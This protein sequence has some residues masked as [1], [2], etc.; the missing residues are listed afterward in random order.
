[1]RSVFSG[2]IFAVLLGSCTFPSGTEWS[3]AT[4]VAIVNY[5]LQEYVQVPVAGAAPV[6]RITTRVD[7]E[8]TVDWKDEASNPLDEDYLFIENTVYMAQI[9]LTAK[10]GFVFTAR[11]FK[12]YPSDAVDTQPEDNYDTKKRVLSTITYKKTVDTKNISAWDLDLTGRIPAPVGGAIPVTSFYAGTYGGTIAWEA[13][14][15]AVGLFR[16]GT[17]YTANVTLY[18]AAGCTLTGSVFTHLNGTVNAPAGWVNTGSTIT[19]MRIDFPAAVD[20]GGGLLDDLDLTSKVPKPVSEGTAVTSFYTPQYTGTVIWSPDDSVFLNGRLYTATI[21]LRPIAGYSFAELEAGFTHSGTQY[22]GVPAGDGAVVVIIEFPVTTSA[23]A[24]VVTDLDLTDKVPKPAAGGKPVPDFYTT[25]YTGYVDWTDT[26][27]GA[28]VSGLFA[29]GTSYTAKISLIAASG[30]KLD[31]VWTNGFTYDPTLVESV[32][33]DPVSNVAAIVFKAGGAAGQTPGTG[34]LTTIFSADLT[35]WLPAPAA[36]VA[37]ATSFDA[38]FYRGT[39]EW[40][41]TD[42][43]TPAASFA[44]DKSYTATVTLTPGPGYWFPA[45]LPVTHAGSSGSIAAFTGEPRQGTIVFPAAVATV[46]YT[47]PFSGIPNSTGS[48]SVIDVIRELQRSTQLDLELSMNTE[49][50]SLA[51]GTDLGE[52]GLVLNS[53]NSSAR[54]V[55]DGKGRTVRLTGG[56]GSVITVG[57]GVTLTLRNITFEGKDD[58]NAPLVAVQNGGHLVLE[59]GAVITGNANTGDGDGGGGGVAVTDGGILTMT[60]GEISGNKALNGGGVYVGAGA[61]FN[62]TGGIIYGKNEGPLTNTAKPGAGAAI[63]KSPESSTS[64]VIITTDFTVIGM[65]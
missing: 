33:Y 9:T 6:R 34:D 14:G 4:D 44:A 19:G 61:S 32:S 54:V 12:Y 37:P 23:R 25:Q 50:V 27:T 29:D 8:I 47:G 42:G 30:Y 28:G 46:S 13:G 20:T 15:A 55:I 58:N 65:N 2:A 11:N 17:A 51:A 21:L 31:G 7:I 57:Q 35:A 56:S 45:E 39:V 5:D 59:D 43:E 1:M 16:A 48:D 64:F 36:G 26:S 22:E 52:T 63:Y 60:G 10:N 49:V 38:E 3:R 53:T 41:Q 62:M 40:R 18:A 24:A